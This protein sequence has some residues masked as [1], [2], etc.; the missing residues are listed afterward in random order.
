MGVSS[1][2]YALP[3]PRPVRQHVTVDDRH[4]VEPVRQDARRQEPREAATDH[5]RVTVAL[6]AH[7]HAPQF[8]QQWIELSSSAGTA[9]RYWATSFG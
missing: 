1:L 6:L 5:H 9:S 8:I 4:A 2:G 3:R 7:G